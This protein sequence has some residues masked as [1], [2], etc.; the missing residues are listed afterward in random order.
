MKVILLQDVAG[1]GKAGDVKEVANGYAR[2]YLLPRK[3]AAGATPAL[4][5]N[6][7]QRVAAERRQLEKQEQLNR[8]LA[9]RLSQVTL[10]FKARVGRNGRLYG[11]VTSQD[12]AD[13]LRQAEGLTIDR[14]LIDLP[15]PIRS[16]GTFEVPV[17]VARNLV[18]RLT[19]RVI[20]QEATE[21]EGAA[22]AGQAE[23]AQEE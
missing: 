14:R 12:I 4:L 16:T 2:N 13:G 8:Q 23:A 3:L 17:R 11:S 7:E 1:L 5:A 18:P 22:V 6:R 20:D 15:S 21:A 9:E 19:V 10:T